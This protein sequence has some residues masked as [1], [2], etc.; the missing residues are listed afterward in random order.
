MDEMLSSKVNAFIRIVA[1]E[2]QISRPAVS[3]YDGFCLP[4]EVAV[5]T[6]GQ[7]QDPISGAEQGNRNFIAAEA[8][9]ENLREIIIMQFNVVFIATAL[10]ASASLA[11]SATVTGF[12]GADCKGT[13]GKSFTVSAGKCFTLG[14]GSTKSLKYSGVPH[15]IKFFISGGGHDSCTNGATSSRGSGSGCETALAGEGA[16]KNN[17]AGKWQLQGI[18]SMPHESTTQ[19]MLGIPTISLDDEDN[20]PAKQSVLQERDEGQDAHQKY[21]L[22]LTMNSNLR[23]CL[24]SLVFVFRGEKGTKLDRCTIHR[25]QSSQREIRTYQTNRNKATTMLH[26]NAPTYQKKEMSKASMADARGH[27]CAGATRTESQRLYTSSAEVEI[28]KFAI[29]L[30]HPSGQPGGGDRRLID[31]GRILDICVGSG[32]RVAIA[33]EADQDRYRAAGSFASRGAGATEGAGFA[34]GRGSRT[35]GTALRVRTEA[36][37]PGRGWDGGCMGKQGS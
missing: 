29:E 32:V 6:I 26:V 1:H 34:Q 14:G 37:R 18:R 28:R 19:E 22:L 33:G 30:E 7:L 15:G 35:A 2:S 31:K 27:I 11:R 24:G 10:V 8:V 17:K 23:A 16:E 12:A 20:S 25:P 36:K 21:V 9:V 3:I 4:K 5:Q 13:K